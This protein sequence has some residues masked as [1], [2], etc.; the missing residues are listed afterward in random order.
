MQLETQS[1]I[2]SI[3]CSTEIAQKSHIAGAAGGVQG[4]SLSV[5]SFVL[6]WLPPYCVSQLKVLAASIGHYCHFAV[7]RM[8]RWLEENT[9]EYN[10]GTGVTAPGEM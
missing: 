2:A 8:S 4:T 5:Y 9:G 6:L 1:S 3:K 7:N 10:G